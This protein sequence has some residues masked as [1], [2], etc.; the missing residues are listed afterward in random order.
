[1]AELSRIVESFNSGEQGMNGNGY[2]I[3]AVNL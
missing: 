2:L 1:M 3:E